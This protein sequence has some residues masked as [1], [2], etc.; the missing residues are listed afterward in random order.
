MLQTCYKPLQ[1]QT[2]DSNK[3]YFRHSARAVVA[4][5]VAKFC[6]HG[7]TEIKLIRYRVITPTRAA[8]RR[9][10]PLRHASR[11]AALARS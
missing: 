8:L 7:V 3:N 9:W 6:L 1:H 2:V 5:D 11:L 4:T 10:R